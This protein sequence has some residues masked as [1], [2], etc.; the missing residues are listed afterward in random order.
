VKLVP[1]SWFSWRFTVIDGSR[2][3]ADIDLK[4]FWREKGVL[5]IEGADYLVRRDALLGGDFI[6]ES[7]GSPVAAA[8]HPSVLRRCFH[9]THGNK[10]YTL[11]A[12]S[13]WARQ[14]VLLDESAEIGS[15]SPDSWFTRRA[16]IDLPEAIPI[17][18]RMFIVWLALILWKR[19]SEA[20]PAV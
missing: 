5:S 20:P 1:K 18:V 12:K 14:F 16:T 13:L 4:S 2:V 15:I 17:A 19:A 11:R 7:A 6:L 10:H 9:I 8:K 3:V